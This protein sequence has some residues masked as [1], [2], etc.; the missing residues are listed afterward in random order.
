MYKHFFRFTQYQHG[1]HQLQIPW[2]PGCSE[3]L[4]AFEVNGTLINSA[5]N[6]G[7]KYG[8]EL[9]FKIYNLLS[10]GKYIDERHQMC[11]ELYYGVFLY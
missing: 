4:D 10:T 7:S 3:G 1:T 9:Y 2:V 6:W 8:L 11:F 5:N